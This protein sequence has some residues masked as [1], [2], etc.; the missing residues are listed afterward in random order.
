MYIGILSKCNAPNT[1]KPDD[2]IFKLYALL[3]VNRSIDMEGKK[4]KRKQNEDDEDI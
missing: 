4:K 2:A 3:L 1:P